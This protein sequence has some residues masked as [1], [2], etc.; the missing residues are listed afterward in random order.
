[1]TKDIETKRAAAAAS[2]RVRESVDEQSIAGIVSRWTGIPVSKLTATERQKLLSLADVLH[3]RVVGQDEAVE[4]VAQAVLRSRAGLA[5][6]EQ[7]TGSFLFLGPTGV[8]KSELAKALAVEL[9]DDE[10]HMVS[11]VTLRSVWNLCV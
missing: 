6:P 2:G 1:V 9:F 11:F 5:R 3:K 7:P 4:A 8:G 10:K